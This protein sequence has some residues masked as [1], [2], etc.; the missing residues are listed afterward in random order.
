M[1][2]P[3]VITFV[4]AFESDKKVIMITEYLDGGEL[5]E[6]VVDEDFQLMESECCLFTKQ[7]CRGLQYLHSNAIV[8]LDIK[9]ENIV[10]T[11]KGGKNIKII[12]LGTALR[13]SSSEKVQAMVGTAEFVAPEVVN[14]DD[15]SMKTGEDTS[16]HEDDIDSLLARSV[17]P[18]SSHLH[19]ALR[20]F[21]LSLRR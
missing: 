6:R 8:H 2:S 21:S 5:F 3:F 12:D 7:I 10:I 14:Y 20:S 17:V 19:P 16:A 4:E 9:P 18:G 1:S 15:I 11:E 13:L